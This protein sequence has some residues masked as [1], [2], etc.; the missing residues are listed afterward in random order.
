V[1]RF[2]LF[3][4]IQSFRGVSQKPSPKLIAVFAKAQHGLI[5]SA[6]LHLLKMPGC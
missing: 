4:R 3:K 2:L 1:A 5:E 6:S